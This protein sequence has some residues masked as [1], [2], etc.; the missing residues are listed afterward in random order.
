MKDREAILYWIALALVPGVGD[1]I[2]KNLIA[3]CG[4]PKSVFKKRKHE[5]LHIPGVGEQ[6][7][8]AILAFSDFKKAEK[9]CAFIEKHRIEVFPYLD[10]GY[11]QRLKSCNDA[12]LLLFSRGNPDFNKERFIAI[13]GTRRATEYGKSITE[14]IVSGLAKYDVTVVSGLALGID[15]AAH[16][17]AIE[18]QLQTIAVLAH[19]L[20]RIYPDRHQ[21]AAKKMLEHGG[22]VTEFKSFDAFNKENFPRRNRIIAGM[23]DAV[24]VIESQ[25]K[26]GALITAEIANSYNRDV[27]SVPG[28]ANDA[29]SSGCNFLIKSNKASMVESADDIAFFMNWG[30]EADQKP[31]QKNLPADLTEDE[32]NIVELLKQHKSIHVDEISLATQWNGSKLAAVLLTLE[33]NGMIKSLPGKL[34]RLS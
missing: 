15:I 25:L 11:S 4:D 34:Y 27:F 2:A 17:C 18:N 16:R 31:I 22:L 8:K 14:T 24:V 9:E 7:A 5:L 21:A 30:Q 29:C 1:V 10:E 33:I 12:P 23:S 3:Y 28:R 13:I 26:G 19:G 32:I 20:N 6:I